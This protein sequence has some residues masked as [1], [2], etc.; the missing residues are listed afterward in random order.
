MSGVLLDARRTGTLLVTKWGAVESAA[1][2][3]ALREPGCDVIPRISPAHFASAGVTSAA[4]AIAT[5][6]HVYGPALTIMI[7]SDRGVDEAAVVAEA[8]LLVG[9]CDTLLFI[10]AD[11][12]A[13]SGIGAARCQGAA[14][15]IEALRLNDKAFDPNS[16]FASVGDLVARHGIDLEYAPE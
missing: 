7:R 4:D 10:A 8:M 6:L 3:E 13:G 15:L 11:A 16:C 2:M 1:D 9:V 14:V 5:Q 12:W